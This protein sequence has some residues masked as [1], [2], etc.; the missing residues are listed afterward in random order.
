MGGTF[1]HLHPGHLIFLSFAAA[2]TKSLGIGIADPSI[3]SHKSNRIFIQ[4]WEIRV[5]KVKEFLGVLKKELELD[6]FPLFDPVCKAGYGDFEVV[7]LTT[8]NEKTDE[9]INAV[10]ASNSLPSLEKVV[11][12][13]I[14]IDHSK[15]SSTNVRNSLLQKTD[16][17]YEIVKEH[18]ENLCER[19]GVDKNSV[20]KWWDL[21]VNQY[22]RTCRYYHTIR[23][24]EK[25]YRVLRNPSIS[26]ELAIFFHDLVYIPMSHPQILSNEAISAQYFLDFLNETGINRDLEVV[27]EYI[28]ATIHHIPKS[29]S[30]EELEFLDIDMSILAADW[31]EYLEYTKNV[32]KEYYWY[33]QDEFCGGRERILTGFLKRADIY[34]SPHFKHL[35]EKARENIEREI[36]EVLKNS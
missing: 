23:H 11:M 25:C 6:I 26:I 30:P 36:R 5:K 29:D 33:T 21:I 7:I 9:Q 1:D 16:N 3:L 28:L 34:Y 12:E 8:E 32:R 14:D 31:E 15:I 2:S 22:S 27:A 20:E 13:L 10:R 19:L 4:P 24:I 18:W 35:E 17:C